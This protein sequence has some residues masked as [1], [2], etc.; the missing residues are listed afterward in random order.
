MSFNIQV[1]STY[2]AKNRIP[3]CWCNIFVN[4]QFTRLYIHRLV[5]TSFLKCELWAGIIALWL[6]LRTATIPKGAQ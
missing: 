6:W 1:S 4:L 3:P 2:K 5:C